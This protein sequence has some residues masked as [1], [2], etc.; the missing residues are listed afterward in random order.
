MT[1]IKKAAIDRFEG[2]Q[3]VLLVDEKPVVVLRDA[4]PKG[5]K[6]GDWLDVEFDG[7][8]LVSARLDADETARMKARI[9]EKLA[10]LRGG[11]L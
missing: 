11:K 4:L 6:Q 7:A 8:R 5:V 2:I 9:S 10:R 3:A 1:M